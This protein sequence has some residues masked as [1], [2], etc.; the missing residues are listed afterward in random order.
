MKE[1]KKVFV[2]GSLS[3]EDYIVH[4]SDKIRELGYEVDHVRKQP[5]KT[6]PEL[7]AEAYKNIA[8]A[9]KII[10]VKKEDGSLGEGT[11]YELAFAKF[12]NKHISIIA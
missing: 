3:R 7:I 8:E 9:D 12:L 4:I 10:V 11:M 1:I 5:S 6:L 2:I